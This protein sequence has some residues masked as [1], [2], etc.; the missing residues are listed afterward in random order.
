[1]T[2]SNGSIFRVTVSLLGEFPGHRWIPAQRPVMRKIDTFSDMRLNKRWSIRSTQ[3]WFK[4]PS[5]SLWRHCNEHLTDPCHCLWMTA[6]SLWHWSQAGQVLDWWQLYF[7]GKYLFCEF[8]NIFNSIFF[9]RTD[10][11]YLADI[12][13]IIFT[14][15]YFACRG[16]V[17]GMLANMNLTKPRI[18]L[19]R[20]G[21]NLSKPGKYITTIFNWYW[22]P[23]V[24]K[25]SIITKQVSCH[26]RHLRVCCK[27]FACTTPL[28][29]PPPPKGYILFKEF[30]FKHYM[31]TSSNGNIFRVTVPLWGEC[32]V[33]RWIPLT[34]ASDAEHWYFLRSAPGK[35]LSIQSK[36]RWFETPSRSL[37]YHCNVVGCISILLPFCWCFNF[38]D[39]S[40]VHS[41]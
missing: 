27:W 2:S 36:K 21:V 37:S 5:R 39:T 31:I 14:N 4:T 17:T 23:F 10:I 40:F 3:R 8:M 9:K 22:L 18:N 15:V 12:K 7:E 13:L 32:T 16:Q 34:K 6:D 20:I 19:S 24:N 11:R 35:R 30:T 28:H 38:T 25:L 33:P 1:M 26:V 29:P 41:M